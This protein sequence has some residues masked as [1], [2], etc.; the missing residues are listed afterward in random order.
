LAWFAGDPK[1]YDALLSGKTVGGTF[2][3]GSTVEIEIEGA[4]IALSEGLILRF[5]DVGEKYPS[6]HQLLIEFE[7]ETALSV[8]V[9]MYGGICCFKDGEYDN[10]YYLVAKEK[11]SPLI[12]EF[13]LDYFMDLISDDALQKK[14]MKAFLA[15]E[16]RIPG[17][18]NGV[19][20]DVL[21]N[22]RLHPK[23]KVNTLTDED[24][25]NLF[26]MIKS[27]LTEMRANG[28]RDT[29]KDLFGCTGGYKTKLGKNT[30]KEPCQVCG[31]EIVKKAYMGGSVYYCIGCQKE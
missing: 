21:F 1:D 12:D 11:P 19:L 3:Y 10:K 22:S 17:F 5:H 18:G 23:R 8:K 6:K 24:K 14:S 20:Q 2:V 15:T 9:Q 4:R 7:D 28:G 27:T 30:V 29:E 26:H 13:D 25:E 31:G 16:Q